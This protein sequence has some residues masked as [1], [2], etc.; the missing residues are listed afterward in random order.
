MRGM[1]LAVALTTVGGTARAAPFAIRYSGSNTAIAVDRGSIAPSGALRTATSYVFFRQGSFLMSR[2]LQIMATRQ[3]VDCKMHRLKSL[4]SA[5]YLVSGMQI[6]ATGPD[7]DWA[8]T[9]RGSSTDYIITA[10]C[11]GPDA[12]WTTVRVQTA[13]DLYRVAW[14]R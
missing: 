11:E 8:D 1:L 6:S 7:A 13:F 12:A 14:R 3:V 4:G 5:G 9:L 10:V 2:R